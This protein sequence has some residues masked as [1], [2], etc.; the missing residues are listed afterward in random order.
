MKH[1][2][3]RILLAL[4]AFNNLKLEQMDV[5]AAFFRGDLDENIYMDQTEGFILDKN[6]NK[7]CLLKKSLYGHKK[8]L[9]QWYKR[10]DEYI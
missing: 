2:S 10:F 4:V 9:R 5:K 6:K 1:C 3:I 7:V 8:S